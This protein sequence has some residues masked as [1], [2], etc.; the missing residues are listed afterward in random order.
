LD[1][2]LSVVDIMKKHNLT[3]ISDIGC[4]DAAW[5][6]LL[7]DKM[8]AVKYTGYEK[9]P[10]LVEDAKTVLS[11]YP[12]ATIQLADPMSVKPVPAEQENSSNGFF[13]TR[14]TSSGSIAVVEAVAVVAVVAV[15]D[16]VAVVEAVV[17]PTAAGDSLDVAVA[18][19]CSQPPRWPGFYSSSVEQCSCIAT[20]TER[21]AS[22]P[23]WPGFCSSS[24]EQFIRAG[25]RPEF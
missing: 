12:N 23:R 2:A 9:S 14:P 11:K 22:Y 16:V 17:A 4:L 15:V 5:V 18:A 20:E 6:P 3:S 13:I 8:P 25:S 7:L 10:S 1:Y 21:R 24:V 19:T